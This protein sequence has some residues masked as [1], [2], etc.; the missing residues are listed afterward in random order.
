MSNQKPD[1][2]V[3]ATFDKD[4]N[5]RK[6]RLYL[7]DEIDEA[8]AERLIKG[9]HMLED[10]GKGSIEVWINSPGGSVPDAL[11]IYDALRMSPCVIRTIG[12]GMVAS[13]A[14]Y[15]FMAGQERSISP[16]CEFMV[17]PML[18]AFDGSM[19]DVE[20]EMDRCKLLEKQIIKIYVSRTKKSRPYWAAI[21]RDRYFSPEECVEFGIADEILEYAEEA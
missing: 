12:V 2:L 1:N 18:P 9:L 6:R 13:A 5:F 10:A 16:H 19:P 8:T 7:H 15:I 20:I 17:H 3:D 4:I 14:T 11:A 21:K